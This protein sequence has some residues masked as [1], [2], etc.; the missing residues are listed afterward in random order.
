MAKYKLLVLFAIFSFAIASDSDGK[1]QAKVRK[2]VENNLQ[3]TKSLREDYQAIETAVDKL[4]SRDNSDFR[5]PNNTL[6]THY[7]IHLS[8]EI[9]S[10]NFTFEGIVRINFTVL[11]TSNIITLHSRGQNIQH[12][13]LNNPDGTDFETPLSFELDIVREFLIISLERHMQQGQEI[14][15]VITFFAELEEFQNRG[16]IRLSTIDQVTNQTTWLATSH[17]H[18]INSRHGYPC[19]DEV[20]FR[21]T[22]QLSIHHHESYHAI[23]NT[24]VTSITTEA[25]NY[26]T[27][28]FEQTPA[29]PSYVLAFTVSSFASVNTTDD[30]LLFRVVAR[31]EAIAAGQLDNALEIG[32]QMLRAMENLFNISYP[33]TV[34]TQFAAPQL[35]SDGA[36]NWGLI[37][38]RENILIQLNDDPVAQHWREIRLGHEFSVS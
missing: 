37:N 11:E 27:T 7:D 35:A 36:H 12:V 18:P 17:F 38:F 2:F 9:H 10:G 19:Y 34:S 26:V 15:V 21:A 24:P 1:S 22:Y 25:N 14:T 8:T 28:T 29:I 3:L 5:L 20:R 33:L 30:G 13:T 32:V 16:F 23:S 6:P 31:P 4:A